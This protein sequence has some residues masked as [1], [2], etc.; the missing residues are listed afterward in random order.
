MSWPRESERC[1]KQRGLVD[2]PLRLHALKLSD[3]GSANA[4][5]KELLGLLN[6][7]A[8]FVHTDGNIFYR[9]DP[10]S[11]RPRDRARRLQF[12]PALQLPHRSQRLRENPG[13]SNDTVTERTTSQH[14]TWSNRHAVDVEGDASIRKMLWALLH[15]DLGDLVPNGRLTG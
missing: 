15:C 10:I 4:T 9:P 2:Q 7:P 13:C 14:D 5:T 6:R 3:H 12:C 8:Y 11:N 1:N